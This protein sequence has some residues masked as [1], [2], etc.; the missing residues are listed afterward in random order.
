VALQERRA[1]TGLCHPCNKAAVDFFDV[2]PEQAGIAVLSKKIGGN[3]STG[4][5]QWENHPMRYRVRCLVLASSGSIP[6]ATAAEQA[7]AS[8]LRE[9]FTFMFR[10]QSQ[11]KP[12][13]QTDF[14]EGMP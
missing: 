8:V 12:E 14:L 10:S 7:D 1:D 2:L 3:F 13:S 11:N 5:E 4:D 9:R 6:N